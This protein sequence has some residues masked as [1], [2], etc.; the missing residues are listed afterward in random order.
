MTNLDDATAGMEIRGLAADLMRER[1]ALRSRLASSD[2]ERIRLRDSLR[3]A[4]E[5]LT[6]MGDEADRVWT[7]EIHERWFK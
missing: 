4:C 3:L 5:R 1:D 7:A 2:L 6:L